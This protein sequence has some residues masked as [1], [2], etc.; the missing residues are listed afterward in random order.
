MRDSDAEKD[1][2]EL[3][4][5][6]LGLKDDPEAIVARGSNDAEI[7]TDASQTDAF[8]DGGPRVSGLL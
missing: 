2:L 5:P 7:F 3:Q 6:Q 4:P 1:S 8:P